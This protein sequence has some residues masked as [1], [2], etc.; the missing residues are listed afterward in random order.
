MRPPVRR[1]RLRSPTAINSSC[2]AGEDRPSTAAEPYE[3]ALTKSATTKGGSRHHEGVT[4]DR[5]PTHGTWFDPQ[6]LERALGARVCPDVA[7]PKKTKGVGHWL[8]HLFE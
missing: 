1:S 4:V 3:S 7:E 2:G 5:C 8:R 6:E